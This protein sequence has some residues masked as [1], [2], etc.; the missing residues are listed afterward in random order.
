M[1]KKSTKIFMPICT[2]ILL[3]CFSLGMVACGQD[4]NVLQI[5]IENLTFNRTQTQVG[6]ITFDYE[7][8]VVF[9]CEV[10]KGTFST[11]KEEAYLQA[12]NPKRDSEWLK[13]SPEKFEWFRG[14]YPIRREI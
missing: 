1:N 6:Y 3:L 5:D 2:L 12:Y 7:E 13:A 10:S 11:D 8:D 9:E 4:Q 14:N